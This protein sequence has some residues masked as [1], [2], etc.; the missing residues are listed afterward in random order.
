MLLIAHYSISNSFITTILNNNDRLFA[1]N[2]TRN[3]ICQIVKY[4]TDNYIAIIKKD[5]LNG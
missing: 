2:Y 5:E 1:K 4:M 3:N